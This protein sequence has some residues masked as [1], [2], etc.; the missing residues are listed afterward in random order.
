M[1]VDQFIQEY[2]DPLADNFIEQ[3]NL[4]TFIL[5]D[6]LKFLTLI[7]ATAWF[8]KMGLYPKTPLTCQICGNQMKLYK[9][10]NKHPK[11]GLGWRCSGCNV[12]KSL[13]ARGFFSRAHIKIKDFL[14]FSR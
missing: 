9:A 3:Q 10:K 13:A 4:G 1:D 12:W 6:F 5:Y 11:Q 7:Q 8:L 14:I 2:T